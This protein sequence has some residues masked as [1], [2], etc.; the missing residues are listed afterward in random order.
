MS[1]PARQ[2]RTT[3][4]QAAHLGVVRSLQAFGQ[5]AARDEYLTLLAIILLWIER[6]R[7]R[8]LEDSP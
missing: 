1:A 7:R 6:E 2:V 4:L 3:G 5:I 8:L